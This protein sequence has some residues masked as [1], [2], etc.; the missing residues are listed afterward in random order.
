MFDFRMKLVEL[1]KFGSAFNEEDVM[2][3]DGLKGGVDV[4][5]G[6]V[7]A[8]AQERL[9]SVQVLDGQADVQLLEAEQEIAGN[10]EEVQIVGSESIYKIC[11]TYT[12]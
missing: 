12:I 1:S 2:L 3:L 4:G 6:H 10:L 5:V 11:R 8:R 7:D 9:G